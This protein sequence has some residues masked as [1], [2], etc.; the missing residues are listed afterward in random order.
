MELNPMYRSLVGGIVAFISIALIK[1]LQGERINRME[2]LK[3]S[4]VVSGIVFALSG[5]AQSADSA[6]LSEPFISSLES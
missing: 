2:L 5:S 1:K 3:I 4:I 6:V